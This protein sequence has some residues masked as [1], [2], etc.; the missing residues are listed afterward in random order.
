MNNER[1][2]LIAQAVE[3]LEELRGQLEA[4]KSDVEVQKDLAAEYLDNLPEIFHKLNKG[5]KAQA[6]ASALEAATN[7]L[8]AI[9]TELDDAINHLST[10]IE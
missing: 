1:R 5:K 10:A 3:K 2:Q 7:S 6:A 4:V 9:D 8:E